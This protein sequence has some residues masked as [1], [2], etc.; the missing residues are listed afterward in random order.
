MA[1]LWV[2]SVLFDVDEIIQDVDAACDH[3]KEQK[4]DEG[5]PDGTCVEESFSKDQ[6]CKNQYIFGPL[7]GPKRTKKRSDHAS[8]YPLIRRKIGYSVPVFVA[9]GKKGSKRLV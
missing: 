8:G 6:W 3:T 5:T 1:F 2:F 9:F 4:R 7:V